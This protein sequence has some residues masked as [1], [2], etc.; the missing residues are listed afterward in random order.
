MPSVLTYSVDGCT[1]VA[2]SIMEKTIKIQHKD[3][4]ILLL[5]C[6]EAEKEPQLEM[7]NHILQLIQNR[8]GD[9]VISSH[10]F[11]NLMKSIQNG[12][13]PIEFSCFL[14]LNYEDE[15]ATSKKKVRTN[16]NELI[17]K[18]CGNFELVKCLHSKPHPVSIIEQAAN[19]KISLFSRAQLKLKK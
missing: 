6:R 13:L 4:I 5:Q 17:N 18:K 15:A 8:M 2:N 10:F 14:R 7:R 19:S 12:K 16:V 9:F 1:K 3:S 11:T